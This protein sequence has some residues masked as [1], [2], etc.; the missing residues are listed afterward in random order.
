MS[1]DFVCQHFSVAL[2]ESRRPQ[3]YEK[4]QLG[5]IVRNPF[6]SPPRKPKSN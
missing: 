2:K 6:L 4:K 5:I 3:T 1:A